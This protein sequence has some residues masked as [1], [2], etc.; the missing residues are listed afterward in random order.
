MKL[1]RC[2]DPSAAADW[3][4]T[5]RAAG[6]S[7]GFVPTMGALHAGHLAL[8]RRAVEENERVCV[9]VFVNPLQFD[10]PRDCERYPRD[11]EADAR[12]L[13][14]ARCSM[15]FTGTLAQ[16]FPEVAPG[17]PVPRRAPGPAARGLE[18]EFRPGHFAGVATICARLF[19]LV[20]PTRAYF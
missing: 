1:V 5:V 19:E 9:S 8:V 7:L 17:A 14:G 2:A 11:L 13:E 12:L 20:R 16:F 15:L 4:A 10:D 6:K 3:C 18:G